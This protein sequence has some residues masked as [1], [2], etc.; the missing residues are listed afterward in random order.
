MNLRLHKEKIREKLNSEDGIKHRKQ[1][2]QDVEATF[3]PIK[4]NHN[5]KRLRLKGLEKVEIEVGLACLAYIL[6]KKAYKDAQTTQKVENNSNKH[7]KNRKSTNLGSHQLNSI[8]NY[9]LAA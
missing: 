2:L 9:A 7:S 5:F 1:R 3:R 6:R 8:K 4:S